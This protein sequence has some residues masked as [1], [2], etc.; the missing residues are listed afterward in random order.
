MLFNPTQRP[1]CIE[2]Q[3][4]DSQASSNR[5]CLDKTSLSM[6]HRTF[7]IWYANAC[8]IIFLHCWEWNLFKGTVGFHRVLSVLGLLKDGL[9]QKS[10]FK[11]LQLQCTFY[12]I[13]I[14]LFHSTRK[15]TVYWGPLQQYLR[16]F[17]CAYNAALIIYNSDALSTWLLEP[18]ST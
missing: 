7:C 3:R 6:K 13:G 1:A 15:S 10:K 2:P 14:S 18:S 8:F 5:Q 9:V 17:N 16:L 12:T 11:F 4:N